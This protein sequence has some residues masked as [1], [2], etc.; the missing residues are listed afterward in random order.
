MQV[1]KMSVG[2]LKGGVDT[3]NFGVISTPAEILV[4]N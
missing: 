3:Q 4:T 2:I 1:V